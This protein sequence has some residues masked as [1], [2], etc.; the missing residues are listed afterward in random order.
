MK[1][2]C[3]AK[4]SMLILR[5]SLSLIIVMFDQFSKIL[6]TKKLTYDTQYIL[7][8]FLNLVLVH[9]RGAAFGFL[10]KA[11]FWQN[12]ALIAIGIILI[13]LICFSLKKHIQEHF[14]SLS[15][16]LILG[17]A[18]GNIINRITYGYVIDF[19]DVHIGLWH[20]PAFNFADSS[21]TLGVILLLYRELRCVNVI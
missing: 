12:L 14:L 4:N 7:T 21:I 11:G 9:N 15:L 8:S 1:F 17:G 19:L 2:S 16:A 13:A 5:F 6:I 10:E 18:L 3:N 20:W